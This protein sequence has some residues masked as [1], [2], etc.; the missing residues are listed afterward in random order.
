MATGKYPLIQLENI[1][2]TKDGLVTGIPCKIRTE[3]FEALA[4]T[5]EHQVIKAIDG[6]PYLQI[7]AAMLGKPIALYYEQMT[8]TVYDS[9][10]AEIQAVLDGSKTELDL[11]VSNFVYGTFSIDVVPDVNP[12]RHSGEQIGTRTQNGSF[13]FV[14]TTN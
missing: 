1:F 12:V 7:S 10:V 5:K 14:T 3:G 6:T 13:H 2:L 4:V 8:E 11:E 9:I